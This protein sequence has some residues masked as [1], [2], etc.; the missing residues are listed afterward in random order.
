[1]QPA[2]AIAALARRDRYLVAAGLA[3]I[4]A[5]SWLYLIH[6]ATGM[7][8]MSTGMQTMA[9]AMPALKAWSATDS[10]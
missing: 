9:A 8:D 1:M 2:D 4:A 7:E 6:L 5:L 3:G 10:R